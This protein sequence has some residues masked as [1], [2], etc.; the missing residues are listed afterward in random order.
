MKAIR[1]AV[2]L[3]CIVSALATTACERKPAAAKKT[4]PTELDAIAAVYEAGDY[5]TA[6][7]Q[8]TAYTGR[9]P[10]DGLAWTILGNAYEQQDA[11]ADIGPRLRD[12]PQAGDA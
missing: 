3:S 12:R 9:Y 1:R 10:Q 5:P 8:L 4:D 6:V 7:R 11:D 2:L